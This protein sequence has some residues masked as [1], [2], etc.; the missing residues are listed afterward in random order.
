MQFGPWGL[1]EPWLIGGDWAA[2]VGSQAGRGA[3]SSSSSGTSTS[4]PLECPPTDPLA[5]VGDLGITEHWGASSS[6]LY[7]H[8]TRGPSLWG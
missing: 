6:A 1:V 2:R 8:S 5:L 7:C 4:P 3:E